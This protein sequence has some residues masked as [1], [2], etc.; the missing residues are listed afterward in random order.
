MEKL[1]ERRGDDWATSAEEGRGTLR[2][3]PVRGVHPKQP[4]VSEW[5]N[6]R[7]GMVTRV[8]MNQ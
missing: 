8:L 5:G 2:K 3:A 1:Q 6:P 7:D 4:E